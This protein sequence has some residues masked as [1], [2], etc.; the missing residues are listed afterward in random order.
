[1]SHS[2]S[3][4]HWLQAINTEGYIINALDLLSTREFKR[5]TA[6]NA[7]V[8]SR[9]AEEQ[10]TPPR[11]GNFSKALLSLIGTR[12]IDAFRRH[13]EH[14]SIATG[15][16]ES[17]KNMNRYMDIIPYDRTR[18]VVQHDGSYGGSEGEESVWDG[19]YLNASWV[20]ERYGRKWWIAAQAPLQYTAH[21]FLSVILQPILRPPDMSASPANESPSSRSCRVRTVVQLTQDVEGGRRK[22][23]PY[24]P[25]EIGKSVTIPPE[26]GCHAS[27][28]KVTLLD[29]RSIQDAHC[30]LSTVSIVPLDARPPQSSESR[31]TGY[32]DEDYYGEENRSQEII[33]NHLLYLSWPDHGVPDHEDRDSLLAFIHLVDSTNRDT[34][35]CPVHPDASSD[36]ACPAIDSDPPIMVGCSA[37]VGRTGSF[38]ALSSLL[39]YYG[40][41]PPTAQAT[42]PRVDIESPL[43]PIPDE[44]KDDL[45]L[46]E[47]DSLREQRPGMVQ[48]AEQVILIYEV[49]AKAFRA[50][51]S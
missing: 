21:A 10:R 28:L 13:V 30:V 39:R 40:F 46:Q 42:R 41:L 9:P 24:F 49:L 23:D 47:I 3:M 25:S 37:G 2:A 32:D 14:Y 29:R 31:R 6:R 11:A 7:S 19:R 22:A 48:R 34:S 5:Y 27:A 8:R 12:K 51:G 38:I 15:A 45:V 44:F 33:F 18:V 50:T 20:Q 26:R 1:M 43:G 16:H 35:R 36:H 4:P 17:H